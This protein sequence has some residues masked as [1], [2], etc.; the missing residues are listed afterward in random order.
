MVDKMRRRAQASRHLAGETP[1]RGGGLGYKRP[2]HTHVSLC[3]H[4]QRS[5]GWDRVDGLPICR[6]ELSQRDARDAGQA[7]LLDRLPCN[8]LQRRKTNARVAVNGVFPAGWAVQGGGQSTVKG[9][10]SIS[11]AT[12]WSEQRAAVKVR[13]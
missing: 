1:T 2:P 7:G 6:V 8:C 11:F 5:A 4:L 9:M 3:T 10:C 13:P 12:P